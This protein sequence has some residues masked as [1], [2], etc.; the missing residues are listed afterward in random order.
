V[1]LDFDYERTDLK[2]GESGALLREGENVILTRVQF[3]F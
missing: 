1:K 3:Q 2:G